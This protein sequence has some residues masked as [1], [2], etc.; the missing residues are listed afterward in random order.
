MAYITLNHGDLPMHG[1][2]L[3]SQ[4]LVQVVVPHVTIVIGG[5]RFHSFDILAIFGF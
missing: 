5:K 1:D 4:L 2:V 3:G